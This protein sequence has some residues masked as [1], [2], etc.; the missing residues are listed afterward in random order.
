[1]EYKKL[2][3]GVTGGAGLIGSYLIDNLIK[4]Y[5]KVVVIDDFS[6][7]QITNISHIINDIELKKGD[8]EN[9][10]F[11]KKSLKGC[12]H[13]YHLASRAYG[14]GYSKDHQIEMLLHNER[15]TNNLIEG[16]KFSN[17]ESV[18]ITSSSCVYDDNGPDTTPELP[19][20]LDDPE[21][22]NRGYGW[23]KRF[24]E[25]KASILSREIDIKTIIVRPF[26]VFG[27]RYKWRGKN[28]H[29]IPMLISKVFSDNNPVEV[30]G[31]GNQRRSYLHA[32][33][34]AK[35]IE[36]LFDSAYEKGPI[37]V[38]LEK[39]ISIKEAD[40]I[41]HLHHKHHH[42]EGSHSH[43]AETKKSKKTTKSSKKT[44]KIRKK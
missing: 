44:K 4:K 13:I 22:A 1:M 40:D 33:D 39:T 41:M 35:I 18:L 27:E 38:G 25:A 6:T 28:S 36:K 32:Y 5:S 37:N 30:W 3:V 19:V 10:E 9:P 24:L 20:F 16:L 14:I 11:C 8:L 12:D 34:C 2:V 26:N 42:D 31:S 29:T 17:T 21:F 15:V 43:E 23:A 7:G